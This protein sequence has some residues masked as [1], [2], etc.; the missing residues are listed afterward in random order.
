MFIFAN[1]CM[2]L[3][4]TGNRSKKRKIDIYLSQGFEKQPEIRLRL[5]AP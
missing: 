2:T 4:V 3:A 1:S 5:K